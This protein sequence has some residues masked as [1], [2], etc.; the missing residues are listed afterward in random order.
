MRGKI[1]VRR[2]N[3]I[4][5]SVA[6]IDRS[7]A[8]YHDVFGFEVVMRQEG[9]PAYLS[10]ITGY[11]DVRIRQAQLQL[12]DGVRFEIF[13][14]QNPRG[15][16]HDPE[17]YHPLSTHICFEVDDLRG[18]YAKLQGYPDASFRSPPVEV[19]AG[20]NRGG[21]CLYLRDPDGYTLELFQRP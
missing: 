19:T 16:P 15:T 17:T 3:H 4:S 6:D 18:A 2:L 20:A 10:P 9:D 1:A 7:V 11:P 14:Y 13:E 8:F 21:L 5:L 12:P